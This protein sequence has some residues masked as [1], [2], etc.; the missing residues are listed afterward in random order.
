LRSGHDGLLRGA[1]YDCDEI[2]DRSN[3]DAFFVSTDDSRVGVRE[4]GK[5]LVALR[6]IA[7]FQSI[8]V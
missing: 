2:V 4:G 7:S 5:Y 3:D 8:Y 1:T 6:N